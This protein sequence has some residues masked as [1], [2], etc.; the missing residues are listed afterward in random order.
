MKTEV[1]ETILDSVADG[2]FT[3]D[4]DWRITSWNRAAETITGFTREEAVGSHCHD[5]FR[6]NVCQSG[7]V[8][9]RT[10]ETGENLI[11]LP[12]NILTREG[13][14]KPISISTAALRDAEGRVMGGVETFRDLSVLEDLRRRLRHEYTYQDIISKNHRIQELFQILPDI[15]ESGSTVLIEGPSG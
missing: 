7:C 1:I 9:R 13:Y 12:I 5:V 8:L 11:N 4:T 10:L 2:V 14:E 15:A 3:V 6:A